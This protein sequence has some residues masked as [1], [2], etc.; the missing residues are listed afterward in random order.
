[1]S[2]TLLIIDVQNAMITAE[3]PVY[4]ASEK[5]KHIHNLIKKARIKPIPV[6]YIQHNEPKSEFEFGCESWQ[7]FEGIYPNENDLIIHKTFPD[8]FKQTK[9]KEVLDNLRITDLVIVGMQSDYCINA[10]STK[11]VE[12]GYAVTIIKDAHST[13]DSDGLSVEEI[14]QRLHTKWSMN[15]TLVNESSFNF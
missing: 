15:M 9:L 10:T 13:W 7:I 4:Q 1:M 2:Y 11:A 6:I 14:I 5:I 8:S 3:T 12:L